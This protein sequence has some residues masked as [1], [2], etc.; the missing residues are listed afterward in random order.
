MNN[1]G[2]LSVTICTLNEEKNISNLEEKLNKIQS[3]PQ[4]RDFINTE[5]EA[6]GTGLKVKSNISSTLKKNIY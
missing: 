6:Y 1:T 3:F 2:E 5:H 4:F